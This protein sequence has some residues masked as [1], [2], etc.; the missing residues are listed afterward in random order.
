MNSINVHAGRF[1][2]RDANSQI[3]GRIKDF[4]EDFMVF[5]QLNPPGTSS[6]NLCTPCVLSPIPII[7]LGNIFSNLCSLLEK[8][9]ST[10][11]LSKGF[12]AQP[13]VPL[14]TAYINETLWSFLKVKNDWI[15]QARCDDDFVII[16]CS[17]SKEGRKMLHLAINKD[18]PFLRTEAV[19]KSGHVDSSVASSIMRI[20][21]T[22]VADDWEIHVY[23]DASFLD[24]LGVGLTIVELEGLYRLKNHG[25]SHPDAHKGS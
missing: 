22:P 5:E 6:A 23:Q 10:M 18:F 9:N 19:R 17:S 20:G 24:L 3:T 13:D 21:D 8:S 14:E 2:C 12:S 16:P 15:Q 4:P 25:A 11:M 1:F 7:D